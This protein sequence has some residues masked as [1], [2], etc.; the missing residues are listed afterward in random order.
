MSRKF[1]RRRHYALMSPISLAISGATISSEVDL[2]KLRMRELSAIDNFA[3][4]KATPHDFRDL[5]DMLNL[6]Q[7]TGETGIGAEVLPFCNALEGFL[8]SA[9]ATHDE[10]GE[11]PMPM[12]G[13]AL[14][15][16]VFAYH[17]LQRSSIDRRAYEQAIART[18][19][20]IR[21]AHPAVKVLA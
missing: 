15:R 11:L 14:M 1:C 9:K 3:T 12:A 16:D 4:G 18:R 13:L 20:K 8:L 6:A 2:D 17:D 19:N 10:T 21:S 7:T 5:A